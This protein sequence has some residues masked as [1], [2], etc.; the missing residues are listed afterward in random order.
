MFR[1]VFSDSFA[2]L[3]ASEIRNAG[4]RAGPAL[5]SIICLDHLVG[6]GTVVVIHHT[7]ELFPLQTCARGNANK[8]PHRLW[9][10]TP[11]R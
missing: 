3:E 6:V 2:C 8:V 7:G 11:S 1:I 10:D 5:R 4:G 9:A